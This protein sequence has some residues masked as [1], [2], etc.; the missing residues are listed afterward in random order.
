MGDLKGPT[1]AGALAAGQIHCCLQISPGFKLHWCCRGGP[2]HA[3]VREYVAL[4]V[5]LNIQ[6]L[7]LSARFAIMTAD[8]DGT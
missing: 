6:G 2:L 8:L 7:W 5:S 3:S 4:W 1:L